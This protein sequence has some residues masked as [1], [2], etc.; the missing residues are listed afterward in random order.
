M[1]KNSAIVTAAVVYLLIVS[2]GMHLAVA[3]LGGREAWHRLTAAETLDIS[4]QVP[5][6]SKAE[7][8]ER[9]YQYGR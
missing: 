7:I 8:V 1:D 3:W 2:A 9:R 4:V 5:S 6:E